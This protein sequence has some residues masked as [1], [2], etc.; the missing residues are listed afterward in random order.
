MTG[1]TLPFDGNLTADIGTLVTGGKTYSPLKADIISKGNALTINSLTVGMVADT[2]LTAKGRVGNLAALS[3]FDLNGSVKTSDAE[4]LMKAFA[5][6]PPQIDRKIGAASL[7]GT[8][9]GSLGS[10]DL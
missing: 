3:D 2:T 6:T 5:I 9:K 10:P 1:T 8:A 7:N 4:A